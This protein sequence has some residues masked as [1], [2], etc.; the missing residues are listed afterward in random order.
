MTMR[1]MA[2]FPGGGF[3][4]PPPMEKEQAEEILGQPIP[5]DAWGEI[6]AAFA[7]FGRRERALEASKASRS[8][9]DSQSWD[10]RQ[11]SAVSAI[12]TAMQKVGAAQ[13]RHGEFLREASENYCLQRFGYSLNSS[14]NAR[15]LL[16]EAQEKLLHA[17]AIIERAEAI[18]VETPT[19]ATSRDMLVKDIHNALTGHGVEARASYGGKLEQ[20]EKVLTKH[21]S[22]FEKLIAGMGINDERKAGNF[23]KAT[24]SAL[25]GKK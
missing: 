16:E 18:E 21:L 14:F 3:V 25:R 24:R 2:A 20:N 10:E 5:P 23:A 8:K 13:K 6:R 11:K 17:V 15:R 12:D 22:P 7:A 1:K 19:E 4:L 9:G